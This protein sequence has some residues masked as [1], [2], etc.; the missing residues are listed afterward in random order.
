[1]GYEIKMMIGRQGTPSTEYA[2]DES[3][4]FDDGSGFEYLKDAHG[5]LVPTGRTKTWFDVFAQVDL[6]KLGYQEHPLNDLISES[7]AKAR[8]NT[9]TVCFF[10]NG[11]KRVTEDYYGDKFY[12]VPIAAV[13]D[14]MNAMT[15]ES[16]EYRRLKWAKALVEAMKDDPEQLQVMFFG[17]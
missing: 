9:A 10:Y 6:C 12:P 2:I 17:H 4:P 1:M 7:F 8:E 5:G 14:A 3:K 15:P 16:M 11:D 13:W